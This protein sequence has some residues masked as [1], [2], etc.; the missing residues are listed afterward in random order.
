MSEWSKEPVLKTG[1]GS[2]VR[3]FESHSLLQETEKYSRGRRGAPAK[4]VGRATGARVQIP[5]S[6]PSD[7]NLN[8]SKVFFFSGLLVAVTNWQNKKA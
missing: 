1:D 4:G 6:P 7:A 5:P 3:G 8:S 2:A